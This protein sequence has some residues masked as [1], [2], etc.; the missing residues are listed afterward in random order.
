MLH[1][2]EITPHELSDGRDDLVRLEMVIG[3]LRTL[4]K[5]ATVVSKMGIANNKIGI[6]YDPMV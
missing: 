4:E 6:K 5:T 1:A 3:A 2:Y